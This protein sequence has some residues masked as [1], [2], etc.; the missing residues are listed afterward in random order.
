MPLNVITDLFTDPADY[1][2]DS[3]YIKF[4]IGE[5]PTI[6]ENYDDILFLARFDEGSGP[7]I[8][9]HSDYV[10][11]GTLNVTATWETGKIAKEGVP[12]KAVVFPASPITYSDHG[13][14]THLIFDPDG[15]FVIEGWIK[16]QASARSRTII[17][18]MDHQS[19]NYGWR[20]EY[21]LNNRLHFQWFV[22]EGQYNVQTNAQNLI[23]IGTWGHYKFTYR[24]R[25]ATNAKFRIN[26]V[27][28]PILSLSSFPGGILTTTTTYPVNIGTR[29]NSTNASLGEP[30]VGSID[31]LTIYNRE[32]T[33]TEEVGLWNDGDG[34]YDKIYF[35][36]NPSIYKTSGYVEDL[37]G[38][39]PGY[40]SALQ[41]TKCSTCP[42]TIM[43][44]LGKGGTFPPTAYYWTGSMWQ[45]DGL[46]MTSTIDVD[47][48]IST[49]DT[50][51][52]TPPWTIF[53]VNYF[54]SDGIT[55][56]GLK[57]LRLES[58]VGAPPVLSM[59]GP[60]LTKDGK[61]LKIFDGVSWVSDTPIIAAEFRV[62]GSPYFDFYQ[63][64]KK[65]SWQTWLEAVNQWL[66]KEPLLITPVD[67]Q[68][69]I[70]LKITN[71][72]A[73]FDEGFVQ[74][75]SQ[76]WTG[77][78]QVKDSKTLNVLNQEVIVTTPGVYT[79]AF[80]G[81]NFQYK[82]IYGYQGFMLDSENYLKIVFPIK[83]DKDFS[84]T[85]YAQK[86]FNILDVDYETLDRDGSFGKLLVEMAASVRH[87]TFVELNGTTP[88]KVIVFKKNGTD[89][90]Y[91]TNLNT[92][93]DQTYESIPQ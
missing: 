40:Y 32:L 34:R 59:P 35:K 28:V 37:S 41:I 87:R 63:P 65:E 92:I 88:T 26:G 50:S 62:D 64:I 73:L 24:G 57:Q 71:E 53:I 6:K 91:E 90:F 16:P 78:F 13:N 45:Q 72:D 39:P 44:Q 76:P 56:V 52:A 4:E 46:N 74:L 2:F 83:V 66:F 81:G 86:T 21:D 85:L 30:F 60:K 54:V 68:N 93:G 17:S 12:Q 79:E 42:G 61:P 15:F 55:K 8:I 82:S 84:M 23:P 33:T 80:V 38:P 10:A 9:D 20:L 31:D 7:T 36:N 77:T 18:K 58:I 51:D 14:Q 70:Y 11:N 5:K 69:D 22:P 43:H 27:D 49:F 47:A 67:T 25:S 29:N 19:P 3:N 89:I 75:T 1:T 48:N